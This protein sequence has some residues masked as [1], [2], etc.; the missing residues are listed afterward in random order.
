VTVLILPYICLG[1]LT[2]FSGSASSKN[3]VNVALSSNELS[4]KL[5]CIEFAA[6]NTTV[7]I[8]IVPSN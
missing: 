7:G 1:L 2:T 4:A 6:R 3:V 5:K 8:A